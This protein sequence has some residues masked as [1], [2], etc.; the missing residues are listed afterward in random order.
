MYETEPLTSGYT[1]NR[2]DPLTG[3][4]GQAV[5][6]ED[7][8]PLTYFLLPSPTFHS[9]TSQYNLLTFNSRLG[10]ISDGRVL[11]SLAQDPYGSYTEGVAAYASSPNIGVCS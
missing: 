6:L 4:A 10:Y 5:A 9:S 7:K 1:G 11:A 2:I 3:R 8:P